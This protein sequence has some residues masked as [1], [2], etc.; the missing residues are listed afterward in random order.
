MNT[1]HLF[2]LSL[3]RPYIIT[4]KNVSEGLYLTEATNDESVG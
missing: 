1:L 2:T 4:K 3:K